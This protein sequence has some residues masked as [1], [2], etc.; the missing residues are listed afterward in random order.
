MIF[1]IYSN[2][3]DYGGGLRFQRLQFWGAVIPPEIPTGGGGREN[4][5]PNPWFVMTKLYQLAETLGLHE[6]N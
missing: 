6:T 5:V 3:G 1:K 2:L 4:T